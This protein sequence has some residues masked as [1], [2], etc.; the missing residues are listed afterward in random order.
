MCHTNNGQCL[1]YGKQAWRQ[2]TD[3]YIQRTRKQISELQKSLE[4]GDVLFSQ[5]QLDEIRQ[6][7]NALHSI[8]AMRARGTE[9]E[10]I[11]CET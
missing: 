4:M 8:N 11:F 10:K 2:I 9:V 6:G 1:T 5:V 3:L 7:L